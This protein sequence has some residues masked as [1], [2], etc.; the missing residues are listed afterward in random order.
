MTS[1]TTPNGLMYTFPLDLTTPVGQVRLNAADTEIV[2]LE[3]ASW[4]NP[5]ACA[6]F[7]DTEILYY[8]N[9]ASN[10]TRLA[11]AMC[12]EALASDRSKMT[13]RI[14]RGDVDTD[15]TKLAADLR[16]QAAMLR[17]TCEF[18]P[19]IFSPPRVFD[20]RSKDLSFGMP[21]E[22]HDYWGDNGD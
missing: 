1:F 14:K 11:A 2:T 17:R 3:T 10:N 5:E 9:E 18:A 22:S 6:S 16:E 13:T 8:L 21:I 12:L 19:A 15:L 4:V 20:R 7:S